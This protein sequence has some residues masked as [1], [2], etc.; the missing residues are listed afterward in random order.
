MQHILQNFYG[1]NR[2]DESPTQQRYSFPWKDEFGAI[3]TVN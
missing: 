1:K 3:D 2:Q